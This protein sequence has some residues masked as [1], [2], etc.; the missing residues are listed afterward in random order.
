MKMRTKVAKS[1]A[2]PSPEER[3]P[4]TWIGSNSATSQCVSSI[5]LCKS[6]VETLA[7]TRSVAPDAT[8]VQNL[9]LDLTE[10]AHS[11]SALTLK[12]SLKEYLYGVGL[13]INPLPSEAAHFYTSDY[14][15]LLSD[16][17]TTQSDLERVWGTSTAI[18]KCFDGHTDVGARWTKTRKLSEEP[19][20]SPPTT[21]NN[22]TGT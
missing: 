10:C 13:A 8:T 22:P 19:Q 18:Q 15:A 16:W 3:S 6:M 21:R 9:Y 4:Q 20:R 2:L 7:G 17:V 1:L 14:D 5:D 11:I 12:D